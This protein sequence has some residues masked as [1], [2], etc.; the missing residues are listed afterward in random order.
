MVRETPRL[1][2]IAH[3]VLGFA[4]W[5]V[6]LAVPDFRYGCTAAL[7]LTGLAF[8]LE[9]FLYRTER[10]KVFPKVLSTIFLALFV[11]LTVVSWADR[12]ND[13][14]YKNWAGVIINGGIALGCVIATLFGRPFVA[15]FAAD[16]I[17]D[18]ATASHPLVAHMLV[19]MNA[20]WILAFALMA[21]V[22]AVGALCNALIRPNLGENF[23]LAFTDPG[24]VSWIILVLCF[25]FNY[26]YPAHLKSPK[27]KAAYARKHERELAQWAEAHPDHEWAKKYH[28][29]KAAEASGLDKV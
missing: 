26:A 2:K 20:A 6:A 25:A 29:R 15:D 1:L 22:A 9:Y 7:G 24:Y 10:T 3:H 11:V 28:E 5:I 16:K 21:A 13:Q 27:G 17:E 4:P 8:A 18:E 23:Q 19:V 12:K 14:N